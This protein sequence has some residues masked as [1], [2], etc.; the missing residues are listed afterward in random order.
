MAWCVTRI[1]NNTSTFEK[2]GN[3][4]GNLLTPLGD[5]MSGESPKKL[6]QYPLEYY[7][8]NIYTVF[9]GDRTLF[10][11]GKNGDE[12]VWENPEK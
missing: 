6:I 5:Q 3:S 8:K 1:H 9:Q 7:Q 4:E 2:W 12:Y 10:R 11:Y